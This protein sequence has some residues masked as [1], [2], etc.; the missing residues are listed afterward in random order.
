MLDGDG[1]VVDF[2]AGGWVEVGRVLLLPMK[3]T[4]IRRC[5]TTVGVDGGKKSSVT[6]ESARKII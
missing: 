3:P 5:G 2:K 1:V 4:S 6:S